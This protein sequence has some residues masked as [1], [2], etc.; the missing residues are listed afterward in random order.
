M[1]N[2]VDMNTVLDLA[3]AGAREKLAAYLL[4]ELEKLARAGADFGVIAANTPHLVFDEVQ[5]QSPIPLISIVEA[6]CA[7]AQSLGLKRVGL[8]GTRFTMQAPFY[9]E[10]FSRAGVGIMLPKEIEQEYIHHKYLT[11]LVR[12]D[13]QPETREQLVNLV[14]GLKERLQIQG[15]V[16][17]GTELSLIFTEPEVCGIPVLDTT[18]IHVAAIVERLQS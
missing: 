9:S 2:S 3:A 1:L 17:G 14:A 15:L 5:R 8:F 7:A 18:R 4:A 11:E 16:L 12:G 10:V 6:T 13:I